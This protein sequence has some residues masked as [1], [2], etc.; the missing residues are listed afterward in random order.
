MNIRIDALFLAHA[1][2]TVLATSGFKL[3]AASQTTRGFWTW[4]ILGN[5]A[6]FAGVLALTGL[7]RYLPV[8]VVYPLS[9][10]FSVLA[11]QVIAA[12]S[13]FHESITPIQWL[14]TALIV[15]GI[16]LVGSQH[17]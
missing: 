9:Q 4:Q 15:G 1:I 14:G 12:R 6:G 2:A 8:H 16:I 10:G 7:L 11:I 3:S 13:F 5:M 17:K